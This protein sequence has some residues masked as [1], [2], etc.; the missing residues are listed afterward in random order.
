MVHPA[1]RHSYTFNEYLALEE[2]ANVRHEFYNG[3]IYAVAGGTPEHAALSAAIVSALVPQLRNG[4]CRAYTADLRV[5]VLATGLTTYPHVTVICGPLVPHPANASTATNPKV[6]VEV[7]SES[8]AAYD[9]GEKLEAYKRIPSLD[10]VL[11]FSQSS[12]RVELHERQGDEFR[13]T[14]LVDGD[15]LQLI[16]GSVQLSL[17]N[18]YEDAGL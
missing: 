1:P 14:V 4:P 7:L 10:A 11:L 17:N 2:A 9:R 3:E 8:T 12:R 16:S 13:T 18:I 15:N 5:S 6:V